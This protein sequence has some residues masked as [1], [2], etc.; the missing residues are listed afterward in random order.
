MK[1]KLLL[2]LMLLTG[3]LSAQ[4]PNRSLI[5]T[6]ARM[7][8]KDRDKYVELTNM[9]DTDINLSEYKFGNMRPW[10]QE[11]ISDPW[12]DPW[13]PENDRWFF[14]PEKI[15]KPGESYVI[16]G[17]WDFE[18]A[19]Y[20][21]RVPGW[22]GSE[23]TK[24]IEFLEVADFLIHV[25][26]S[27]AGYPGVKDSA[28]TSEIY[29]DNYQTVLHT[30]IGSGC[31]YIEHH[32]A[33][34]DSAVV[35]QVGGVFD[36]E[37]RNGYHPYDVAGVTDAT[38]NS[39]LVRKATITTG[40]LDFANARGVGLEDSEWIP[41]P[42][43]EGYNAWRD[44]WWTV[45]NHGLYNL[46]ENTLESDIINID[47]DSKTLT[48]PWGVRRLDDIMRHMKKKSGIA[49]NYHLNSNRSDSLFLSAR[50]GDKL[51]VYCVGE[52]LQ[53]ATFD[54]IVTEPDPDVNI[55]V[56]KA[57]MNIGSVADGGPI[58]TN[59]QAGIEGL[60]WP[61]VTTH[62]HGTDSIT[63][64][65]GGLS[66]SMRTDTL[67]KY[68][69]IPANASWE[70]VWVDGMERA[71]LK[72]GDKLKIISKDGTPK[73][74]FIKLQPY[75]PSHNANLA[76]ITWPDI[77]DF[78]K[79]IFGW[80]GDTIPNFTP[81]TYTYRVQVPLDVEGIP[82]LIAK[83]VDLNANV[84]VNRAMSLSGTV[85]DRTISYAV[86]AEDDSV[87]NTYNV[88]LVK[89][90]DPDNLQPYEAEPFLSELVFW[91]SWNNSFGEICNPGNE[92]LDL[93]DYMIVMA[94]DN[95][96]ASAIQSRMEEDEWLDRYDKYIPGYK[97][98]GESDWAITPGIVELD[99][100]VN[101]IVQPGDVFCLGGIW[102]TGYVEGEIGLENWPIPDQLDVQF[103]NRSEI[104]N[105][106]DEEVSSDGSPIRKWYNSNWYMFKILNDS[107]KRGLKPANDPNDFELIE[108]F[109]MNDGSTW[110]VGG[111]QVDK[112]VSLRR[113]PEVYKGNPVLEGSFGTNPDDSEWLYIGTDY[114]AD[115]GYGWP[116]RALY[117]GYDI[118]QHYMD[119][120]TH[121]KSTV[122]SAVYKVTEGYSLN[123]EIRGMVTGTTVA[124]F[125]SN[126]I[127][128]DDKQT[129]TVKANSD[130][131]VLVQDDL[132]S[133]N[134][135]LVVLSADSTN[136][137][138]YILEVT[139]DGLS[140]NAVL[141]S[142]IYDITTEEEEP[143]SATDSHDPGTGTITGF[144]YGTLLKTI[145]N[146]VDVPFGATM[147]AVDGD[148]AY[149]PFKR[150]N[151][152]TTYVSVSVNDNTYLDVLA[153]DGVTRIVYQLQPEISQSA[154]FVTSDVYSVDQKDLLIGFVP[155]GTTVQ[156]FLSNIVP[157]LGASVKLVDKFGLERLDGN[158][159]Q[160][161]KLVV[162]SPDETVANVY[163]LS[164]L[165][166]QYIQKTTYLAYVL[167][168]VYS[169]NQVDYVIAGASGITTLAE[170]Y[171]NI[172]PAD[173][174][175]AVVLDSD[176][177]E[178]T[179]GDLDDGDMLKVTSADGDIEVIYT[180]DLDLTSA[181]LVTGQ[182]IEIYPNPTNDK[183]NFEGV[184][185]G[186]RI[187]VFNSNG[188]II[189]D[190]KVRN[191][192]EVIS[193]YRQPAGIYMIVVSDDNQLIGRFKAL[194]K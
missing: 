119:E 178:K 51:T 68:L 30:N 137:T 105:P 155:R 86:T 38:D 179:S 186:N 161:D 21:K 44:L 53:T 157:S 153:E 58:R 31:Y 56:P 48:V 188:A 13:V 18:I 4:E 147:S 20:K 61:R 130:G 79:G 62:G 66:Y 133:L 39:I 154:A 97:W 176:G 166:T 134:D 181:N 99:L 182:P 19:M 67:L 76:S 45:G 113:K 98:V 60:D 49:W 189:Y 193:L 85:E 158:I 10:M 72:N 50:T 151:F 117:V 46:D 126:I 8:G 177:V 55:V 172:T 25:E 159:V 88:E 121:Y 37:G 148:G 128:A 95:D 142:T 131:T 165:R 63:G 120:P 100:N 82:S 32:F 107:I 59:T 136:T 102:T 1:L 84:D 110:V 14:L 122:S 146:N 15:L 73:E 47:F 26:E 6:E 112:V 16:T 184:E 29:G 22:E 81:T 74:Y 96:P 23:R 70:F 43:P 167:S 118:G 3:I 190:V 139:D 12:N 41:I 116:W 124:E 75:R 27:A 129:L 164:M 57:R 90:K 152:D 109:G 87:S 143:K 92:P 114:Y 89:E 171:S 185:P 28:T 17:W 169:V 2:F 156:T 135:T 24:Q 78:Y 192:K 183:L 187:Q 160:D 94:Y 80:I 33:E 149:V 168:D 9:G 141:T 36:E 174:A 162:T 40:N 83:T 125:M 144:E 77:P 42:I 170:F 163:Y 34:G 108:A 54:I 180:L 11:P 123:E 140:S 150:L 111:K 93:S 194:R 71:D 52:D 69:E 103:Y 106:W 138:K 115:Q 5:I 173:G 175:T 132:L 101:P 64:T 91:E 35:D 7:T 145:V 191:S 104:T 65:W 127:K